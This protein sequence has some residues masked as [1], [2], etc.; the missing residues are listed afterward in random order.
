MVIFDLINLSLH[1]WVCILV[2]YGN[3]QAVL[4]LKCVAPSLK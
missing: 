1:T 4:C 2:E 3:R